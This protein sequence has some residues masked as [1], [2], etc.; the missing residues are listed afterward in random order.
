MKRLF[1]IYLVFIVGGLLL[2]L[3]VGLLAL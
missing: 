1:T 3:T 2:Y